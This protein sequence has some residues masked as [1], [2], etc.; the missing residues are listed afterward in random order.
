MT[1][2][3]LRSKLI[4]NHIHTMIYIGEKDQ[5]LA[6]CGSILTRIEDFGDWQTF[7]AMLMAGAKIQNSNFKRVEVICEG[8]DEIIKKLETIGG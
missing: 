5:T 8:D 7:G 1:I 3:K 2:F 4:G 6:N